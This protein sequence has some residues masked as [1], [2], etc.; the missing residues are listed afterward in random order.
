LLSFTSIEQYHAQLKEDSI[1]CLQAVQHYLQAIENNK[2]L[3]C[4]LEVF[5]E[6]ALQRASVLDA[7]PLSQRGKL[8]GVVIG[9]KDLICYKDHKVSASSKILEN[10]TSLFSA[11]KQQKN[12]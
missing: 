6:E 8:H 9:I 12:N 10:F 11:T 7:L 2:H 4:F 3:N 5:A 1:T